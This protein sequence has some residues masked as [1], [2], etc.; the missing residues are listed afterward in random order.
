MSK[1]VTIILKKNKI[2]SRNNIVEVSRGYA[3]N[4]LIP[5]NIAELATSGKLKHFNMFDKI[6]RQQEEKLKLRFN[7]II[8]ILQIIT[9]FNIKKRVGENKQIFGRVHEKEISKQ[10]FKYTNYQLDKKNIHLPE[11]KQTGIYNI[12]SYF[13]GSLKTRLQLNIIP[14]TSKINI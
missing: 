12:N 4:Y 10:I 11:I 14:D 13:Y 5:Q 2:G 7:T 9:K 8:S 3:F 6:N 1:K